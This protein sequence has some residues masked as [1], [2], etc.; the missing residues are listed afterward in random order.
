MIIDGAEIT[1]GILADLKRQNPPDRFLAGIGIGDGEAAI[2][3]FLK[4]K[5]KTARELGVDFR[6]YSFPETISQDELRKEVLKIANH[7]TCG[8]AMVE[9]PLPRTINKNY[10]LN[11]IPREKDVDVLGERALGAFSAGRNP[12]LPPAAATVKTILASLGRNIA[13][14]KAAVVGL[15]FLVGQPVAHWLIGRTAEIYLLDQGGD[16]D[17]LK[18]ADLV[19]TGTG[20]PGLIKP[21]MLKNSAIVI[22]FGYGR[23]AEGKICGD[24]DYSPVASGYSQSYTPTPGGT[25]PV[26]VAELL[27]NFYTLNSNEKGGNS[28]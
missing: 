2:W 9:L 13:E 18:K 5:E 1:A 21:D 22:D 6:L 12:V 19:I 3:S 4:I 8:G 15:G 25:G 27:R 17:V 26:L 10:V 24:F 7:K 11:A 14:L 20:S 23:N 16:F 28:E